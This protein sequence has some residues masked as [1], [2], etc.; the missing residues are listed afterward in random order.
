MGQNVI[1]VMYGVQLTTRQFDVLCDDRAGD[2]LIESWNSQEKPSVPLADR[3]D[4]VD[5]SNVLGI[6]VVCS[7]GDD[8][9]VPDIEEPV[10]MEMIQKTENFK[11]VKRAWGKFTKWAVGKGVKLAKPRLFLAPTEVA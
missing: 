11:R 6:W 7:H 1:G 9:G 5:N 2:T 8:K 4:T 3:I 10:T